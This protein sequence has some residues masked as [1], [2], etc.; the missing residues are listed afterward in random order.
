M[1]GGGIGQM[2][3]SL[4]LPVCS[5]SGSFGTRVRGGEG[6]GGSQRESGS[7][8]LALGPHFRH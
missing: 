6:G 4:N 2:A 5:E 7:L 8:K 1:G 3:L